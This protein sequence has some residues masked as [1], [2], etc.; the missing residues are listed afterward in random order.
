MIKMENAFVWK[1]I[2]SGLLQESIGFYGS[3]FISYLGFDGILLKKVF[4]FYRF[5]AILWLG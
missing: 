2:L 5:I 4:K 3:Q 1:F